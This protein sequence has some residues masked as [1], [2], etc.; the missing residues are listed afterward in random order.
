MLN[1]LFINLDQNIFRELW[2]LYL[3]KKILHF[4]FLIKP[5]TY[6]E[7]MIQLCSFKLT[8]TFNS[9]SVKSYSKRYLMR[10]FSSC[11]SAGST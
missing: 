3:L 5:K 11:C 9:C 4:L 6:A 7:K 2:A 8:V 1:K 10:P